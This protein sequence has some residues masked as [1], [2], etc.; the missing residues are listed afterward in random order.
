MVLQVIAALGGYALLLMFFALGK[1]FRT[2]MKK[3]I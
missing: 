2:F 3:V 1:T